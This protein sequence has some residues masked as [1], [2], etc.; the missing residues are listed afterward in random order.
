VTSLRRAST[1]R[2]TGRRRVARACGLGFLLVCPAVLLAQEPGETRTATLYEIGSDRQRVLFHWTGQDRTDTLRGR[3]VSVDGQLAVED[4][5]ITTGGGFVRYGYHRHNIGEQAT[6]ER[7][8]DRVVFTQTWRGQTRVAEHDFGADFAAGPM[9]VHQARQHWQR[10]RDGGSVKIRY[11]VPDQLRPFAFH[12]RVDDRHP[13]HVAGRVVVRMRAA[14]FLIRWFIDPLYL[15]MSEDA[16]V[17]HSIEGRTL[18]VGVVDGDPRPID[19]DMV[20]DP[21]SDRSTW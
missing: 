10:L 14:S 6:V 2:P 19:A 17:L 12:L 18:P 4:E 9:V 15:V 1:R 8:G 21:G 16:S 3:F 5:L 11:A 20:F 7:R 13:E